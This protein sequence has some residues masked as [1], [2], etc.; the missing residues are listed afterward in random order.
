MYHQIPVF[1]L[2]SVSQN[3]VTKIP[4]ALMIVNDAYRGESAGNDGPRSLFPMKT[5]ETH[6]CSNGGRETGR[7]AWWKSRRSSASPCTAFYLFVISL[8]GV[9]AVWKSVSEF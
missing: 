4:L 1:S 5:F 2:L 8:L 3:P 9:A 6:E 7:D